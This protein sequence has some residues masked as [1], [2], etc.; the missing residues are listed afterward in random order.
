MP[1][2]PA[3]AAPGV[4]ALE[5]DVETLVPWID[6][7]PFF[8]AWELRGT[9]P[10][11][12]DDDT[13]GPAARRLY[14]DALALLDRVARTRALRPRGAVG[15]FPAFARGDDLVVLSQDRRTELAVVPQLRQQ[16]TGDRP[17]LC[18]VD[19][20][21][22]QGGPPDHIGAFVVTAGEGLEALVAAFEASHDDYQALLA[23]SLADRLAEAF[24][25]WAHARVRRELWGYAADEQVSP[26]D[27]IAERFRGIRPAPGYP[28]APDHAA[29]RAIFDLLDAERRTGASLTESFAVLPTAAVSGWYFAHAEARYFAVGTLGPDQV[30]DFAARRSAGEDEVRA[31]TGSWG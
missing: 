14:D 12:L 11:L 24:A 9:F 26:E 18:L 30:A 2:A 7:T 3:P 1:S 17:N 19:F 4:V 16:H 6:W 5:P 8:Q 31:L 10:K 21:A 13:V 15:L 22:S 25:E 23:K 20:V 27:A 29:K 28:A